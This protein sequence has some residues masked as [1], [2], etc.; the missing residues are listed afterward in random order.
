MSLPANIINVPFPHQL[1]NQVDTNNYPP[2]N[3]PDAIYY[4]NRSVNINMGNSTDATY[5]NIPV[6]YSHVSCGPI[7]SRNYFPDPS[8]IEQISPGINC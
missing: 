6:E 1:I 4:S 8:N 5:S 7:P 2:S 3:S